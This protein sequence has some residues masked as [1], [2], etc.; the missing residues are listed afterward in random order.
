MHLILDDL[1]CDCGVFVLKS[2]SDG[3]TKLRSKITFFNPLGKCIAV[4][5]GCGAEHEVPVTIEL[6]KAKALS[7]FVLLDREVEP[8]V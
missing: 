7:H 5:K 3:I 2:Y 6:R 4:C 1:R 8:A